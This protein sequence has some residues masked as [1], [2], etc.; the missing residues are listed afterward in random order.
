M[1]GPVVWARA[2][3][4]P[5]VVVSAA[6]SATDLRCD[7]WFMDGSLLGCTSSDEDIGA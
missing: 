1:A 5:S 6:Q 4:A 2:D 7:A 3:A